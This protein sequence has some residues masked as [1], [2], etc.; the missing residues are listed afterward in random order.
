VFVMTNVFAELFYG[1]C[2]IE[3][4]GYRGHIV[5]IDNRLIRLALKL[6]LTDSIR[7]ASS[8][9]LWPAA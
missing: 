2:G 4:R 6:S 3:G 1:F 8:I 9:I 5:I 7:L